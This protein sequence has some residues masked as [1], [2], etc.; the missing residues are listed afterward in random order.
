[1]SSA[2]LSLCEVYKQWLQMD[3][4]V[5]ELTECWSQDPNGPSSNLADKPTLG[6]HGLQSVIIAYHTA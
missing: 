6:L 4:S 1:M 2:T 5:A 3:D